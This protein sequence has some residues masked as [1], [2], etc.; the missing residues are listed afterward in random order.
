MVTISCFLWSRPAPCRGI[1][2][3]LSCPASCCPFPNGES[4][5]IGF[6]TTTRL[7]CCPK[8]KTCHWDIQC[9]FCCMFVFYESDH[10]TTDRYSPLLWDACHLTLKDSRW[11]TCWSWWWDHQLCIC[12]SA[13]P[14]LPLLPFFCPPPPPK[15]SKM[16]ASGVVNNRNHSY[17]RKSKK[18]FAGTSVL[19]SY[20]YPWA[21]WPVETRASLPLSTGLYLVPLHESFVLPAESF[22]LLIQLQIPLMIPPGHHVTLVLARDTQD[23]WSNLKNNLIA[24]L[25]EFKIK[26]LGKNI[27]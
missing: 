7:S 6:V 9:I 18:H 15:H 11:W 20:F 8:P 10:D 22:D 17:L 21:R 25:C 5:L 14:F 27:F 19:L 23:C 24:Y 4:L 16:T 3:P 1:S 12:G 13:E 26:M 2:A